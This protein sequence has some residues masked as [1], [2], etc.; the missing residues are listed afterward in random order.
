LY[1]DKTLILGLD[2]SKRNT[3]V[4][5]IT[6]FKKED[7]SDVFELLSKVHIKVKPVPN[8]PV[9]FCELQSYNMLAYFLKDY[10]EYIDYGVLEG[11]AF[12]G[13]GLTKLASTAAVYQL[14]LAQNN[15]P[16]IHIAPTRVKL[17][18][19]GSGKGS[20]Q[21]VRAGLSNFL[22]NYDT[23]KWPTFDVSDSAAIAVASAIVNL[24][25]ERFPSKTKLKKAKK[26]AIKVNDADN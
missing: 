4:S 1:K 12:G 2:S 7:G 26:V 8:E 22:I 11:F 17:I 20:K 16:I 19:S 15:I 14:L 5:L 3:G 24:Y 6:H 13:Q 9:F 23:I 25:P 18:V 10:I 21:E